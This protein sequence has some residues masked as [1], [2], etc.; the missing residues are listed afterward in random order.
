MSDEP[1]PVDV[2]EPPPGEGGVR[3]LWSGTISFGLVS[4]PVSMYPGN[5]SGG[6]AL[7]MLDQDGTPLKRRFFCPREQREVHP[8][9]I[10]RGYEL[11]SGEY[12]VVSDEELEALEPRKSRDIDLRRFVDAKSI[13][14]LYFQRAYFLVPAG[15][16]NKAYRLLAD[17]MERLGQAG[18][19]T[20]VMR[21]KEY[22]VAILAEGGI[23]RAETLR[24]KDEIRTPEEVGLPRKGPA[25]PEDVQHFEHEIGKLAAEQF[26]PGA[27]RD[28]Y[29]ER[30]R[31]LIERKQSRREG[32]VAAPQTAE[33]GGREP[34]LIDIIRRSLRG[35]S[36]AARGNGNGHARGNGHERGGGNGSARR[37]PARGKS[38]RP[39]AARSGR[40]LQQRSREELY[41]RAKK[42]GIA[43]R[44]KM[45]KQELAKAIKDRG[46]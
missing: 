7:R 4:V 45:G 40:Q 33:Q 46:G 1:R 10:I 12:V 20:F 38:P 6:I 26:E 5:R 9:H 18:V 32:I 23:L 15:D 28:E 43:G 27:L 37:A 31:K 16:S 36:H 19:A 3:P 41:E 24:F 8:E 14:P 39:H 42:L 21:D 29:A 22:L 30:F 2:E 25:Q 13:D 17:T 11:E 44:S 34:D 35:A